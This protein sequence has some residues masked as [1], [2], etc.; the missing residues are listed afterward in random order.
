MANG[1]ARPRMTKL[2]HHEVTIVLRAIVR[3]SPEAFLFQHHPRQIYGLT[4][5]N[6][7]QLPAMAFHW[8]GHYSWSARLSL[9]GNPGK[10][11]MGARRAERSSPS[12]IH[13]K[14]G[15]EKE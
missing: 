13:P 14:L 15:V 7:G 8:K 3:S 11:R 6:N 1:D 10:G 9:L 5:T 2:N 4:D 12:I